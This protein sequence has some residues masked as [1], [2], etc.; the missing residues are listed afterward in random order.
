MSGPTA[1]RRGVAEWIGMVAVAVLCILGVGAVAFA[2]FVYI[3]L[4]NFSVGG[5]G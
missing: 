2:I 3:S 1:A 5:K 4:Q